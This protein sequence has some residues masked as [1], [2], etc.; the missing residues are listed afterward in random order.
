MMLVVCG[1]FWRWR[2]VELAV[3]CAILPS[4]FREE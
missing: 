2:Y 1:A 3:A 4:R